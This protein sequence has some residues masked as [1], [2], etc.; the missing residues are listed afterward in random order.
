MFLF[1]LII[2]WPGCVLAQGE[3]VPPSPDSSAF[4][5]TATETGSF[6]QQELDQLLAPIALYPDAL[7]AQ[8]LMASTYPLEVVAADR[9]VKSHSYLM[10]DERQAALE[11]QTWDPSIKGLV[12]VPQV[13][14]MMDE[15]LDWTEKLGDAFLAQQ[16]DVMETVQSLRAKAQAAGNLIST[17]QQTVATESGTVSIQPTNPEVIYVPV[18]NPAVIYGPWWWPAPPYYWYPPGYAAPGPFVYFGYGVVVGASIWGNCDW[19]RRTVI[20]NVPNYNTFNRTRITEPYWTHDT[21]HRRG[22][23]YRD[24]AIRREYRGALP[25]ADARR[26]YRGNVP[27]RR[28]GGLP[29]PSDGQIRQDLVRPAPRPPESVGGAQPRATPG[30]VPPVPRAPSLVHPPPGAVDRLP[31]APLPQRQPRGVGQYVPDVHAAPYQPPGS[32]QRFPVAPPGARQL[33]GAAQRVP[34]AFETF[35]RGDVARTYSD[36]GAA[37]LAPHNIGPAPGAPGVRP[38]SGGAHSSHPQG[39]KAA[40]H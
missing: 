15:R 35:D 26:D 27:P 25:G 9:W 33:P 14:S 3:A 24:D 2:V 8:I 37:S 10:G 13:L 12:L 31:A 11:G 19:G 29:R 18:Y 40:A 30:A 34:P 22:V 28:N 21:Y 16:Q 23:P 6:S 17:P 7:L 20:V 4:A 5:V 32:G 39:G 36:R 1:V 38:P